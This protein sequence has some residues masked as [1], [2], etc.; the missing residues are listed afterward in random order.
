MG[1][2]IHYFDIQPF[3]ATLAMMVIVRG[4]TLAYTD[5][6]PVVSLDDRFLMLSGGRPVFFAFVKNTDFPVDG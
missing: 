1:L 2:L 5:T 4:A 3:I 6:R